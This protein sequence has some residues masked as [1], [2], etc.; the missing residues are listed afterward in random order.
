MQALVK[1]ITAYR[2]S[3]IKIS[4]NLST[5]SEKRLSMQ[6]WNV[7]RT[8]HKPKGIRRDANI[9]NGQVKVIFS[10]SSGAIGI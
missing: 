5:M 3:S 9:Q 8:L 1:R 4:R 7:A 10:W 6:H 2:K